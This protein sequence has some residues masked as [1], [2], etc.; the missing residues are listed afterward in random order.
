MKSKTIILCSFFTLLFLTG[1]QATPPKE[2][3]TKATINMDNINELPRNFRMMLDACDLYEEADIFAGLEQIKASGSAQYSKEGLK[4]II[5]TIP[6]NKITFIDLRLE[7]HGFINGTAVSWRSEH[8]WANIGMTMKEVQHDE[9]TRLKKAFEQ[10]NLIVEEKEGDFSLEL[11]VYE[12]ATEE[13]VV[14]SL[15]HQYIRLLAIDHWRPPHNIV[16]QFIEIVKTLPDDEWVHFHCAAGKGRTTTFQAMLVMMRHA[17]EFKFEE[18]LL[19]QYLIGGIDLLDHQPEVIWKTPYLQQ[20]L[21]FLRNFYQYCLEIPD[22]T[23]SWTSWLSRQDLSNE[24][25]TFN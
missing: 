7:S 1:L 3:V 2:P 9:E 13:E 25:L 16:D 10:G 18:I 15:G 8:N 20:R 11:A 17:A 24:H 14:H 6:S 4:K 22:F 21:D 23:E 5:S 19:H 12:I